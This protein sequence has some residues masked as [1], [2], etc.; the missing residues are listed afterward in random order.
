M[1]KNDR[2]ALMKEDTLFTRR[3]FL[4]AS[5]TAAAA[6]L[7]LIRTG[8]AAA[9]APR[10]AVAHTP[11]QWRHLLGAQRY[12]ILR[13]AATEQPGSSP[14][15]NEHRKGLFACAGCGLPIF[16]SETKFDS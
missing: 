13:E 5:G 7:L 4:G 8:A 3:F 2:E 11:D 14:L 15:L 10:F 6:S 16:A 1:L 12:A 9:D